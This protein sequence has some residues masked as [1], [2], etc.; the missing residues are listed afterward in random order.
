MCT[1]RILSLSWYWYFF[2][3]LWRNKKTG[4]DSPLGREGGRE[5]TGANRGLTSGSGHQSHGHGI[6]FSGNQSSILFYSLDYN[7][8]V[9]QVI[10]LPFS[11][12]TFSTTTFNQSINQSTIYNQGNQRWIKGIVPRNQNHTFVVKPGKQRAGDSSL[13]SQPCSLYQDSCIKQGTLRMSS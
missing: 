13:L 8:L 5:V 3:Y 4:V 1:N 2:P 7:L 11:S 9:I 6:I 12:L 10:L